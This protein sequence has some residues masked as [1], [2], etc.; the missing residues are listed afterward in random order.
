MG[1]E[2][3]GLR[4]HGKGMCAKTTLSR[5]EYAGC[6]RAGGWRGGGGERTGVDARAGKGTTLEWNSARDPPQAHAGEGRPLARVSRSWL[7][8]GV[9]APRLDLSPML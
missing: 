9:D 7:D 4:S 8:L 1:N 6:V 2:C 5:V 3:V